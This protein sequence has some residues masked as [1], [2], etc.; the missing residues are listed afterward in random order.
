[1]KIKSQRDFWSGVMFTV[2]G[3]G[4][5]IGAFNYSMGA[6][7]RPGPGFFPLILGVI[8]VILGLIIT[9]VSLTLETEDGEPVG[10]FAWKP[11]LFIVISTAV[12]GWALPIFG[13]VITLPL[14]IIISSMGGDDFSWVASI[15]N[16]IVLTGASWGLFV[17]GLS[18]T[19]PLWPSFIGG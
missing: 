7:A 4:F 12:F 16:A 17:K 3:A 13:M 6:S 9:F 15:S 19:I 5:A 18:L 1:M 10:R 8:T 14:L 2:V 11:L